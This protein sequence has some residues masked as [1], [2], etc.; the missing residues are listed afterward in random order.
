[1]QI[2]INYLASNSQKMSLDLYDCVCVCVHD[3]YVFDSRFLGY[4]VNGN[5][6]HA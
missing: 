2:R 3:E 6:A 1:M 5:T 4:Y